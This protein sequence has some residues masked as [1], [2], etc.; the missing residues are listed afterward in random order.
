M[1]FEWSTNNI[2]QTSVIHEELIIP[3]TFGDLL[4]S[5][6]SVHVNGIKLSDAIV[7]IDDFFSDERVVH[8]IISQK[9]LWNI[10]NNN[11]NQNGMNFLIKPSSDDIQLSSVTENGQFKIL[12]SWEPK[13]LQSNSKATIYFDINDIFLKNRPVAV[14]YD[15][16]ITQNDKIIFKQS[17]LSNDSKEKHNTAEFTIPK[18]IT[19]IVHLNFQNL[20]DNNIAKTSIPIIINPKTQENDISIPDW[21]RNNAKWWA[22][23]S[24]DDKSFVQGIQ[25]LIQNRI[26]HI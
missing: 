20:D 26:I 19:G 12:V 10:Y 24:I 22:D 5:G 7:T 6:F 13:N 9:E 18:D 8:F 21:I 25:Y 16:S 1:P 15:F 3:K 11:S 2:N 17:G 23:G 4:V 14:N